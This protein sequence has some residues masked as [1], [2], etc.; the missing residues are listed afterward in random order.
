M[1]LD[2]SPLLCRPRQREFV[3]PVMRYASEPPTAAG[4]RPP[5][6][7]ARFSRPWPRLTGSLSGLALLSVFCVAE[8]AGEKV[9]SGQERAAG[10]FLAAA[11]SGDPSNVA[12]AIH[13][14]EL[15]KL[16]MRILK[17]LQDEAKKDDSTLRG[18]LFGAGMP[19]AEL[20]RMTSINF[21]TALARRVQIGGRLCQSIDGIVAVPDRDGAT[22]AM[23]RCK[24]PR[25]RGTV[26]S[27][28]VVAMKPYG[29]DWKAVV[30]ALIEAQIEDLEKG[31]RTFGGGPTPPASSAPG[32]PAAAKPT[33]GQAPAKPADNGVPPAITELLANAEK[34]VS[35]G[36]CDDYYGKYMS[37]NFRRVTS[38]S[39]REALISTCKN[40]SGTREMLLSTL[41]IV[42]GLTPTYQYEGQ[43]ANFDLSGQ[44]L[45]YDHFTLEQ[46][47]K[48][49]YIAE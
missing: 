24:P 10:E 25:E 38:K 1:H 29:K 17:E 11:A 20:Q 21:Y 16:R 19:L 44:G 28:H 35:S 15:D 37:P 13:P 5:M 9:T 31:R 7:S 45:P 46:V 34:A 14:E 8:A 6:K 42:K 40:S 18:R 33:E 30:P 47:D 2:P 32:A 41:R 49:W 22:L 36:S 12:Y 23:V 39:A 27:V 48:R 4:V 43:R 26:S 3:M